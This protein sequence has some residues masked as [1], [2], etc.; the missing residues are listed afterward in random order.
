MHAIRLHRFGPPENLRHERVPTPVPGPGQLR[1]RVAG[2]GV[3]LLDTALRSG[4]TL[5]PYPLPELPVVPGREVAGVVDEL[6]E[7]VPPQWRGRLVAAHL[8][9]RLGGYAEYAVADPER[10]HPVPAGL[11]V[12]EALAMVGTGRTALGV[13]RFAEPGPGDLVLVLA[14]AGG[15]GSLLV[16]YARH[17]GA[18]VVGAAGG[19][20]KVLAVR[21][22]GADLAVDYREPDWEQRVRRRFGGRPVTLLY[23]G[24]GGQLARTALELLAPGGT[25]LSYGHA[26]NPLDPGQ[27]AVLSEEE[28]GRRG[29][30]SRTVVG[31]AM[32][33]RLG[34]PEGV[35]A[36]QAEA[37]ALAAEGTWRPLVQLFPLA[38]AATAHRALEGRATIGKVVLTP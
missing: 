14:A 23:E 29:V 10:V 22:L 15:L 21:D 26:A 27:G 30:R 12:P 33:E 18:T 6:G 7:G 17:R 1:V 35:R 13:L 24:V 4:A 8:G 25:H 38:E 31:P 28:Q 16:R 11:S 9:D 34:G 32:V 3:H 19:R 36:A 2:A 5:G 37:L 20:A